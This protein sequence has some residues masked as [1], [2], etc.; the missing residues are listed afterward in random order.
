MKLPSRVMH[1]LTGT[2]YPHGYW[3]YDSRVLMI[4]LTGTAYPHGYWGYDSRVLMIW[5]TGNAYPHGYWGY[6][7]RVLMIWLTGNAYPHGYCIPSRVLHTLT[8]TAY[9]LYRVWTSLSLVIT[10]PNGMSKLGAHLFLQ[11]FE[12]YGCTQFEMRRTLVC[13]VRSNHYLNNFH[14]SGSLRC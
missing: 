3:G 2:A 4:W 7:S 5:L 6:D 11:W 10:V 12:I 13:N 1:I 9:S 8:G 14:K